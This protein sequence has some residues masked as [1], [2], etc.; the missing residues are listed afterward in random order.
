V[1]PGP[2]GGPD[3]SQ[4]ALRHRRSRGPSGALPHVPTGPSGPAEWPAHQPPSI[5]GGVCS[6]ADFV[7]D[8]DGVPLDRAQLVAHAAPL[9]RNVV[10]LHPDVHDA[11]VA[12]GR[13]AARHTMHSVMRKGARLHTGVYMFGELAVDGRLRRIVSTTRRQEE[14]SGRSR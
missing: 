13:V 11:L 10:E 7:H 5:R 6:T 8:N 1:A 9:R 3:I 2:R 14:R 4:N 12:G